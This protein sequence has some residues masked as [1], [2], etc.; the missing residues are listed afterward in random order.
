MARKGAPE[1][2]RVDPPARVTDTDLVARRRAQI[3]DA[4]TGLVLKQGFEKTSVQGVAK[5]AGMSVGLV[6]EYVRKKEDI[7]VLIFE[8][9][10]EVWFDGLE[11]ALS[12]GADPLAR[13][14]SCFAELVKS[15]AQHSAI[16]LFYY[17]VSN[18]P[19]GGYEMVVANER[20]FLGRV[21]EAINE[22]IEAGLLRPDTNPSTLAISI[23]VLCPIWGMKGYLLRA[24]GRT[25]A[26]YRQEVT[27]LLLLG[28][29]TPAGR[30]AWRELTSAGTSS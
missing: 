25:S 4:A 26:R 15:G 9:W 28:C 6:Y 8:Y 2:L 17:E 10:I 20:K 12:T 13:L 5:A 3:V 19:P 14:R 23:L 30:R 16:P 27:D 1:G 29:A 22:A 7:L 11:K 24:N 21:M 18:L